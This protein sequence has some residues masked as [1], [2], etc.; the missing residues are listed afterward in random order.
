MIVGV[1][2]LRLRIPGARSLKEKRSALRP[3]VERIRRLGASC[4]EVESQD[5][6]GEAVVGVAV[7]SADGAVVDRLLAAAAEAAE[8]AHDVVL[9]EV[10]T[11]RR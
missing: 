10:E 5:A 7:V 9:D 2:K 4:A 8:R 3:L 6:H 11:E 1:S